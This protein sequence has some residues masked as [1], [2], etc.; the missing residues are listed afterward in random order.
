LFSFFLVLPFAF[1]TSFTSP[2]SGS[3]VVAAFE[4][5]VVGRNLGGGGYAESQRIR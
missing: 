3:A 2:D 4:L 5:L 1:T